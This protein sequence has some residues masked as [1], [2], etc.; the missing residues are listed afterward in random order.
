MDKQLDERLE[1]L[2]NELRLHQEHLERLILNNGPS[3]LSTHFARNLLPNDSA[4][5]Q[6]NLMAVWQS[7]RDDCLNYA[8]L[9]DSGFRV[10]SQNDE[11]GILLRIFS[12][13]GYSNKCVIE[14]GSNC[15]GSEIGVPENLSSNLIVNHCWHGLIIEMSTEECKKIQYFFANNCATRHFHW[16]KDADN[17]YYSPVILN[18]EVNPENINSVI[19]K[20]INCESPDLFIIDI[21]GGDYELYKSI[22]VIKPRVLVVEFEKRFRDRYSVFQKNR[23]LFS[24]KWA[25]SGSVSLGAWYRLLSDQGYQLCGISNAGFNAFFIRIDVAEGRFKPLTPSEFFD[26]H[27]IFSRMEE[28]FWVQPNEDWI[29]NSDI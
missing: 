18:Q 17:F 10:F 22:N 27:P 13:I 20:N 1:V 25:Q 5:A 21:D 19:Q 14:I 15:S 4:V 6:K 12:H 28:G 29:E 16:Q 11:D 24:S 9:S 8:D 2:L 23:D 3:H 26:S 7:R